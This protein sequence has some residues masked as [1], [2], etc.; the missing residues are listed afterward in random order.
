MFNIT[1]DQTQSEG[2][3]NMTRVTLWILCLFNNSWGGA[4]EEFSIK[5]I[6]QI[7]ANSL[8]C[9]HTTQNLYHYYTN[10]IKNHPI[11]L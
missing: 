6:I 3:W 8:H 7:P 10:I 9:I 11:C 2:Q 4:S 5:D 1:T